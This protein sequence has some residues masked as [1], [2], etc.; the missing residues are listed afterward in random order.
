M[1]FHIVVIRDAQEMYVLA[2][3]TQKGGSGK[4]TLAIG[5]S[6]AA[7]ENGEGVAI[8]EADPQGRFQNGK[9]GATMSIRWWFGSP[10]PPK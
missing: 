7:M 2:L 3:V 5:L 10:I 8:V 1:L 4:S 9:S 6:V